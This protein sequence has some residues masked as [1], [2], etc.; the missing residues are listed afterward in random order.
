MSKDELFAKLTVLRKL[1]KE[2]MNPSLRDASFELLSLL[3]ERHG[4]VDESDQ[5]EMRRLG[6][7]IENVTIAVDSHRSSDEKM[8]ALIAIQDEIDRVRLKALVS[9]ANVLLVKTLRKFVC[10]AWLSVWMFAL[11]AFSAVALPISV[12]IDFLVGF[13]ERRAPPLTDSWARICSVFVSIG[14]IPFSAAEPT[15]FKSLEKDKNFVN[16][17]QNFKAD[18]KKTLLE[19]MEAQLESRSEKVR[20]E[21]PTL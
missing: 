12:T 17:T 15:F 4:K 3:K 14:L 9:E 16:V 7:L 11:V 20:D 13:M 5:D 19:N 6:S 8:T 1:C 18:V 10:V 2:I 21:D